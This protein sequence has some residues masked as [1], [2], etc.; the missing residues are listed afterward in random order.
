MTS[1]IYWF[2]NDLR[3]EDNPSLSLACLNSDTLLPIYIH[4]SRQDIQTQWGFQRVG[5][6]RKLFLQE[7]LQDL[8]VQIQIMGSD[9][10]ELKGDYL[11]IFVKLKAHFGIGKIYCERIEAPEEVEQI[12]RLKDAE[13]EVI[14]CWQSSMLDP[15]DLPFEPE[16]MPDIYTQFRQQV[17]RYQLK[18]AK[19][20]DTIIR[21]P[22]LPPT[23]K[24]AGLVNLV[25]LNA[26]AWT[27]RTNISYVG[28]ARNAQVHLNQ[29]FDRRLVDT[30]KK[31]RNWLIGMDYSSKFSPW[32]SV[33][34]ISARSVAKKLMEYEDQY[35][36]ND[37][38]YWL[39][40]EL[41][42]RDY[43]RFLHFKYGSKLYCAKGLS[44]SSGNSFQEAKFKQW[45]SGNTGENFV[46]AAMHELS[47][48][49]F[50][51]NRMR[52]IVA[53][54]W[55]YDMRGDWRAGA[56]W[57]ESQLIDYDVY[58]NQGNWLYIAGKGT[59]PRGGRPFNVKKQAKDHDPDGVYQ[60]RWLDRSTE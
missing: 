58:S 46:D 36:S 34:S 50:L 10:F 60:D 29:Y 27:N 14:N 56:A 31:T 17:E 1:A 3:I 16:K 26:T 45:I 13:F 43:F 32:L 4:E 23:A 51:S 42:W 44:E 24:E 33:G 12:T 47:E 21:I 5:E 35:G 22:P 7:S 39:W 8:R 11:E 57:F 41:L 38:T 18:F 9:L 6:H 55:I 25:D 19:P 15:D 2:R 49:G 54:Y 59:D 30:Y 52:Q 40:L 37:G 28:G 20:I 48:T 53:S